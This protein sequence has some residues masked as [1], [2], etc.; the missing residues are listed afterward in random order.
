MWFDFPDLAV[1]TKNLWLTFNHYDGSDRFVSMVVNRWHDNVNSLFFEKKRLDASK[2]TI[3][4]FS[5][6]M[7]SYPNYFLDV[8]A[9]DL[10]DFFDMLE[11]FDGSAEYVYKLEKYGINRTDDRFWEEYDWFQAEL[12]KAD[13]IQAGLYD[14]NRYHPKAADS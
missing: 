7:G 1:S 8:Q 2:D 12:F 4:F 14:L 6:S 5:G 13:A 3:D 11:N 9:E 10:P